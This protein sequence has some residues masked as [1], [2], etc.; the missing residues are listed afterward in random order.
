MTGYAGS[1]PRIKD[2]EIAIGGGEA[3]VSLA[4]MQGINVSYIHNFEQQ[5]F[6]NLTFNATFRF[7][8]G[9]QLILIFFRRAA[10][11]PLKVRRIPSHYYNR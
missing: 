11:Q 2:G 1:T 3:P 8:V 10:K 7:F 5:F 6:S 9:R 4:E